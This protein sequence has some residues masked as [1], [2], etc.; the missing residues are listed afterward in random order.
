MAARPGN[1]ATTSES[2]GSAARRVARRPVALLLVLLMA[3]GSVFLWIGIPVGWIYGV[4]QTVDTSQPT[5]G[6]YLLLLVAIPLSMVIVGRLL[7][8]LNGVYTRVTGQSERVRVQLPWH[9]SMR[10]ERESGYNPSVLDLVMVVS[11]SIALFCFALW[12]FLFAG[13]PV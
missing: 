2:A 4:S 10:G 8:K 7:F 12:F 5:L 13:S 9:K 11:V 1:D 3:V 6:P